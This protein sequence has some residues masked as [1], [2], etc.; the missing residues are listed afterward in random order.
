MASMLDVQPITVRTW[1][2]KFEEK[3]FNFPRDDNDKRAFTSD[4]VNMFRYLQSLT[5]VR[6]YS[7]DKAIENTIQRF[8]EQEENEITGH[9]N[10][11]EQNAIEPRFNK[12]FETQQALLERLERQEET[13]QK[14]LAALEQQNERLARQ[15]EAQ[16]R[17]DQQLMHTLREIQELR[18]MEAEEQKPFWKRLLKK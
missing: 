8:S 2:L 10:E 17:R 1:A 4:H 11:T 13:Q 7:L 5:R 3:G 6:K 15:E 12:V 14:I 16:E 9:V 18:R